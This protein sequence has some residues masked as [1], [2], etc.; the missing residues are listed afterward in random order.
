M[1]FGIIGP[2]SGQ[3]FGRCQKAPNGNGGGGIANAF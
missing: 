2:N 3:Q 1:M